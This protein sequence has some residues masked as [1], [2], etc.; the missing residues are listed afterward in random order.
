[1]FSPGSRNRARKKEIVA[2]RGQECPQRQRL[3]AMHTTP[4]TAPNRAGRLRRLNEQ[5]LKP[6]RRRILAALAGML[7]QSTLLLPIPLIQGAIIDRLLTPSA[8][9]ADLSSGAVWL[10][11]GGLAAT[12]ACLL[13]RTA[14]VWRGATAMSRVSL[15]VVRDLTDALHRKL[16]RLPVAYYDREQTGKLMARITSDVGSLLIFLNSASLQLACDLILAL[17]ISA[18]LFALDWRL[19]LVA[20]AVLPLHIGVYRLFAAR[21]QDLSRQARKRI[22]S[23]YSLLS[24]RISAVRVVRSFTQ[25]AAEIEEFSER[26]DAYRGASWANLLGGA[27]QGALAVLISGMG[28]VAVLVLGAVFVGHGALTVGGLLAFYTLLT[29]LYNPITRLAQFQNTVAGTRVAVDRIAEALEEPETLMDRPHAIPLLQPRGAID[30]RDVC[31]A[32]RSNDRP[33]LERINMSVK[34]GMTV[35]ILGAS[36][37][38]KS[39]LLALLPRLYEVGE[40]HGAVLLD[41]IDVRNL[42]LKDLRQAV[43]LV[44][45]QATLF[46]GTLRTNLTYA[47]PDAPSALIDRVLEATELTRLVQSLPLGLETHVGERGLSLSGG[48]RQRLALARALIAEPKVLL[49][50]DCTSALDAETESRIQSALQMFLPGRTCFIVS[51]KVSSVRYADWICIL[52]EGRL[53]EQGTHEEL[54]AKDGKYAELYQHQTA[55]ALGRILSSRRGA[56][57]LT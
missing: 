5:F 55:A 51:N 46:E 31:F 24:E 57:T 50:D 17:G 56:W 43:A 36:G 4:E 7:L 29:Q 52:E 23:L 1:M 41:G 13:L 28:V 42:R 15:E 45:Q 47:R 48:Q 3:E 39:T 20:F 54:L 33:A 34:P 2:L 35:G 44:P 8:T 18:T 11:M 14:L 40:G 22:A 10:V 30:L 26:L 6:H 49:L 21:H 12:V 25:E 16:Q 9:A 53:V 38:G 32:Y 19:A 27:W 37:S